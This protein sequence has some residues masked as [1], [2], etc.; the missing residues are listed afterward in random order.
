[1]SAAVVPVKH[2]AAG[3]SRL[4]RELPRDALA[5][6]S[7]A[8]LE[9]VLAALA[10]TPSLDRTAVVTPDRD[11]AAAAEAAGARALLRTDPGLN[12]ALDAAARE[13]DLAPDEP[14]LVV[15]GDVAGALPGDLEALFE[16]LRELG[17]RGA[18]LAPSGDGG[19]AALLRAPS[20][21]IASRF[22]ADSAVAHR[23]AASAAGV[24]YREL[25]LP[26]LAV[27]LD[28]AE[29]V[30]CFLAQPGGGAHTRALLERLGW[31]PR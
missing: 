13:V 31:P 30:A 10:A 4:G 8:M 1:M 15:L 18:V 21:A 22:G 9:D 23:D 20:D 28:R 14:W 25:P 29:D 16:A 27:D 2:L 24:P 19:T 3:K 26:S 12:P 7:L 11:V 17:G 5:A 6:L